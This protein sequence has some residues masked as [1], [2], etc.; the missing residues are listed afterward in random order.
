[1]RRAAG[2]NATKWLS[3]LTLLAGLAFYVCWPAYSGYEIKTS[4][5]THDATRLAREGRLSERTAVVAA[6]RD[7]EGREGAGRDPAERWSGAGDTR[8]KISKR[9]SCR[10]WSMPFSATSSRPRC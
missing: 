8:R 1:M 10:A 4:L 2:S 6:C 7:G 9:G 5:D 3:F